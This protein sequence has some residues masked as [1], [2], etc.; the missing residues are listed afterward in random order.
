[1][2]Q[3]PRQGRTEVLRVNG[4]WCRSRMVRGKFAGWDCPHVHATAHEAAG[5]PERGF[6]PG[7]QPDGSWVQDCREREVDWSAASQR[8]PKQEHSRRQTRTA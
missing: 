5:C 7:P 1:V 3:S 6:Q 8:P 4:G 2:S